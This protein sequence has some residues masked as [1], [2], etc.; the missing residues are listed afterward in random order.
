VTHAVIARCHGSFARI[1]SISSV[2]LTMQTHQF[3]S[4]ALAT[5]NSTGGGD[6]QDAGWMVPTMG[7]DS[8]LLACMY[9]TSAVDSTACIRYPTFP[10][11]TSIPTTSHSLTHSLAH[12]LCAP[13]SIKP[14]DTF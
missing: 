8:H 4:I 3:G 6:W 2:Q 11:P 7:S 12:I 14:L 9:C 1:Q 5:V 10:Y 13:T